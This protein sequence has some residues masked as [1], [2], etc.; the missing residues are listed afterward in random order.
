MTRDYTVKMEEKA[1]SINEYTLKA[2]EWLI[3]LLVKYE[4]VEEAVS[5]A[6]DYSLKLEENVGYV[7]Y[8][9]LKAK[10]KFIGVL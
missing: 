5:E 4:K 3:H 7:S 8:Y 6:Q 10:E 2:K 1:G 9:T